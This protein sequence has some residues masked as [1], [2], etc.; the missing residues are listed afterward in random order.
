MKKNRAVR[1]AK[2]LERLK[3]SK[4]FEKNGRNPDTWEKKRNKDIEILEKRLNV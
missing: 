1:Q 3:A 4:F 2:A